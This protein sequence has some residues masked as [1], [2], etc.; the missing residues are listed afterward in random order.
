MLYQ[1]FKN[2]QQDNWSRQRPNKQTI[3]GG[4]QTVIGWVDKNKSFNK[5][6]LVHCTHCEK[7]KELYGD[8]LFLTTKGHFKNRVCCGC[9][10]SYKLDSKQTSILLNR[11]I[12]DNN[13][14]FVNWLNQENIPKGKAYYLCSK[15]HQFISSF[16]S[17]K[18]GN[19]CQECGYKTSANKIR[20]N[21]NQHLDGIDSSTLDGRYVWRNEEKQDS[22]GSFSYFN[23]V[24]SKCSNDE[25]VQKGLC[26]GIFTVL[27]SSIKKGKIPCRCSKSY[28]WSIDQKTYQINKRIASEKLDYKFLRWHENLKK[29]FYYYCANHGEQISCI[30]NFVLNL[31]DCPECHGKNQKQAYINLVIKKGNPIA[32]KF[33]ITKNFKRR[34]ETQNRRNKLKMSPLYIFDFDSPRDCKKAEI[35]CKETLNCKILSMEDLL[36]GFTET[37]HLEDLQRIMEIFSSFGGKLRN[38]LKNL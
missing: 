24:C 7:D 11:L 25:Y 37:C 38:T 28:R 10:Y 13:F 26:S 29:Y 36:D 1:E 9:S 18:R 35:C 31:T 19:G 21:I 23:Y 4:I 30:N 32:L 15:G 3:K 5:I 27:I 14:T 12:L 2:I 33:G 34:I 6:Y 8:G 17:F 22:R 16:S 20:K